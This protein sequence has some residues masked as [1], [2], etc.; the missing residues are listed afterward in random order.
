M[1]DYTW[2]KMLRQRRVRQRRHLY[3]LILLLAACIGT[4]IWYGFFYT[5]TPEYALKQLSQALDQHDSARFQKYVNMEV[6]ASRAYDDLTVDLFAY[7]STLT[8]DTKTM[9]EKFYILIKP[10]LTKG[11]EQSVLDRI[12]S[13]NWSLPEGTDILKGR[14]LGIDFERFLERSQLRN[15]SFVSLGNIEHTGGTVTAELKVCEDYTQTPFTLQLVLEQ[16]KDG[17]WQVV[18]IKNYRQYLDTIAPLQNSDIASYIDNTESIVEAYNYDFIAYRQRFRELSTTAN[19]RLSEQQ[20]SKLAKL[21][22]NE[23]IPALK[24]RQ[25]RL[26]EVEVP[27]GAQYLARQ[28]QQST[29]TTIKAW[30]HF[31][32]GL[33]ENSQAEFSTAETLHK[34]ELAIDLRIQDIIHHTAISKN[35]PNL[36]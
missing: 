18:Y 10:Q 20:R 36:P 25:Q 35:I 30:Q 22:E 8:A 13:G 19:G 32:K 3:L 14:Q 34:Q 11:L 6:L 16:A 21:L 5:R 24:K 1:D 17:H 12:D 9:F 31:I 23:V 33:R 2:Q 4:A 28:R 27:A 15:T 26:D 29:E 7:D